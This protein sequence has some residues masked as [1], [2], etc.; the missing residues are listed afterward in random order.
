MGSS[1]STRKCPKCGVELLEGNMV[2]HTRDCTKVN[3]T[4]HADGSWE[5]TYSGPTSGITSMTGAIKAASHQA[6]EYR[7]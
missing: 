2:P 3:A 5:C 7:T 4:G 6:L 1:E